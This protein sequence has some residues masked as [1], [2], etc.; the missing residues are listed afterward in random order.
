MARVEFKPPSD[1]TPE[2]AGGGKTNIWKWLGIGCGVIVLIV[3]L[4]MAFGAWKTVSCC[5]EFASSG[6]EA[7]AFS[8]TFAEDLANSEVEQARSKMSPSLASRISTE[9]LATK[10]DEHAELLSNSMPRMTNVSLNQRDDE[11]MRWEVTVEFSP[12]TSDEKLVVITDV[13]G[14]G[15]GEEREFSIDALTFDRRARNLRSEPP[16]EAVLSLHRQLAGGNFEEAYKSMGREF[17]E[18][19]NL[20]A[21]RDYIRAQPP[22]FRSGDVQVREV[23][24]SGQRQAYVHAEIVAD[25]RRARIEYVVEQPANH[26]PRWNITSINPEYEDTGGEPPGDADAGEE[27]PSTDAGSQTQPDAKD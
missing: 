14:Q 26:Q 2:D 10:L 13:L 12:A 16:A 20:S 21:F 18:Q 27:S 17:T 15:E 7:T 9:E 1:F 11:E 24:Y 4:A 8:L 5:T 6:Q 3:G 22:V 19:N 23:D 25:G